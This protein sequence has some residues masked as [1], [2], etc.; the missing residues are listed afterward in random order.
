MIPSGHSG[1]NLPLGVAVAEMKEQLCGHGQG[2]EVEM[3]IGGAVWV[4]YVLNVTCII[5]SFE[6]NVPKCSRDL[7]TDMWSSGFISVGGDSLPST[8][9]A[10]LIKLIN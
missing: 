10:K 3:E 8:T 6:Y 4:E 7:N 2:V 5:R 1:I 9:P